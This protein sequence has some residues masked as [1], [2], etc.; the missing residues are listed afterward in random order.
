MEKKKIEENMLENDLVVRKVTR[1]PIDMQKNVTLLKTKKRTSMNMNKE[2]L[3]WPL[4]K[5]TSGWRGMDNLLRKIRLLYSEAALK[6]WERGSEV[7]EQ[8]VFR[9]VTVHYTAE[10]IL[11]E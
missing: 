9:V 10:K 2:L 7:L 4:Q 5:T 6:C 1:P 3:F 8:E 11:E